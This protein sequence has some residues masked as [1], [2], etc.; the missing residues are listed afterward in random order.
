MNNKAFL[1]RKRNVIPVW[2]ARPP[3]HPPCELAGILIDVSR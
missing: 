2:G 3:I 1:Q